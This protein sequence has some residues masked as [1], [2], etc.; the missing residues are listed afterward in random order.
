MIKLLFSYFLR[1][2]LHSPMA[3]VIIAMERFFIFYLLKQA[4]LRVLRFLRHWYIGGF[5]YFWR[6]LLEILE[7]LDRAFAVRITMRHWLQP[8]YQDRTAVGYILGFIF[9]TSR[10]FFGSFVYALIFL[11]GVGIYLAWAF[12][13]AA[14]VFKAIS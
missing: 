2:R 9:R 7:G 4:V 8:L 13:P 10:I 6:K 5:L 3:N 12:A 1:T 14:L 11:I